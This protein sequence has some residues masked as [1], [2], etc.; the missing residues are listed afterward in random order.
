[1]LPQSSAPHGAR[2]RRVNKREPCPICGHPDW[3][4]VGDHAVLCMR[5]ANDRPSKGASGGWW[6]QTTEEASPYRLADSARQRR[7]QPGR[8]DIDTLDHVYGELLALCPLSRLHHSI[9]VEQH[10]VSPERAATYGTLPSDDERRQWVAR[11]LQFRHGS[12]VCRAVPGIIVNDRKR[13]DLAGAGVLLPHRDP[14]GRIAGFSIRRDIARDGQ[15]RYYRLSSATHGG[16]GCGSAL[17]VARPLT[18]TTAADAMWITEGVKKSDV[19]ADALGAVVIGLAGVGTWAQAVPV[20]R[21]LGS[22]R[23][24]IA[25][26]QDAKS[27]TVAIVGRYR[28]ALA[29]ALAAAGRE[30]LIAAWSPTDGKGID[31][32]LT[33]GHTPTLTPYRRPYQP[34]ERRPGVPLPLPSRCP[35]VALPPSVR[36]AGVALVVDHG[37][38]V[39]P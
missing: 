10:G 22:R 2:F 15:A 38:R 31:D 6:H 23:V 27:E 7:T 39:A 29:A 33:A 16:P 14:Q 35:G 12:V 5:V 13:Q 8:A 17:H 18:G 26:D 4:L 30:V 9:L 32:L 28:D 3:C 34:G 24:V 1:M 36:R 11:Q 20:V 19:A 37:A 21:E 25:F